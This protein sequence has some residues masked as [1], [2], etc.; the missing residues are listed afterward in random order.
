MAVVA[1]LGAVA[2]HCFPVWLKLNGGKGVATAAGV[3]QTMTPH[4]GLLTLAIFIVAVTL[5]RKVSLGSILAAAAAAPLAYALGQVQAAELYLLI[6]LI[7]IIK[8]VANIRRLFAGDES[9]VSFGKTP[10]AEKT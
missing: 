8:H 9:K 5:T 6:A 3:I 7:I 1:G 4:A 10:P 2:G